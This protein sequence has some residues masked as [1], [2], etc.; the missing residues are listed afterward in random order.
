MFHISC[1]LKRDDNNNGG[2]F[3]ITLPHRYNEEYLRPSF[4]NT[5]V[6][7]MFCHGELLGLSISLFC[8]SSLWYTNKYMT[9]DNGVLECNLDIKYGDVEETR[10]V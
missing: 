2:M 1:S 6:R 3:C 7:T 8:S 9:I 5:G 10:I 4:S